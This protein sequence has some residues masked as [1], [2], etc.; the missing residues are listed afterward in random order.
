MPRTRPPYPEE[1]RREALRLL[2]SGEVSLERLARELGVTAQTLRNWRKQA[3]IDAG[4][5][6][7]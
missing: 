3:E 4:E 7:A 5:R 2:R 6:E 1:F